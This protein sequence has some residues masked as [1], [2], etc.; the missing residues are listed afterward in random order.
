[1]TFLHPTILLLL[2]GKI[3]NRFA[4]KSFW[5]EQ[6]IWQRLRES[7]HGHHDR[8]R[9]FCFL[10]RKH[11]HGRSFLSSEERQYLHALLMTDPLWKSRTLRQRHRSLRYFRMY[12]IH[13]VGTK[14]N[15]RSFQK[16]LEC[17]NQFQDSGENPVLSL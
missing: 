5:S 9:A 12:F 4:G 14:K 7:F 1:M 2:A 8:I 17:P 6:N 10:S 15:L 13:T 3:K 16:F 11:D